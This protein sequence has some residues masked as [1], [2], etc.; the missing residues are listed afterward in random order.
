MSDDSHTL[1]PISFT[2]EYAGHGWGR[3]SISDGVTTYYMDPSYVPADPLF[4][5]IAA[6]VEVLTHGGEAECTWDYEPAADRWILRRDGDTFHITTDRGE[7][8]FS[9]TCDLWKFAPR[10][11][12]R[13]VAWNQLGKSIMTQRRCKGRPNIGRSAS[14]WKSISVPS[15]RHPPKARGDDHLTNSFMS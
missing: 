5:L 14:S 1:S 10:C 6:V 15:A 7:L 2:Y 12:W 3:A 8:R 13:Q 9:T 11:G 4:G